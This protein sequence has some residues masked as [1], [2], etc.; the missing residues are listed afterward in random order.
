MHGGERN[1]LVLTTYGIP[2]YDLSA[3]TAKEEQ[4][5]IDLPLQRFGKLCD[6]AAFDLLG[7]DVCKLRETLRLDAV[8][9]DLVRRWSRRLALVLSRRITHWTY[10]P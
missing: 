6:V 7:R 1:R 10:S 8:E 4:L 2:S 5:G 3:D 9:L